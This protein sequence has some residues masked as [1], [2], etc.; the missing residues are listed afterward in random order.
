MNPSPASPAPPAARRSRQDPGENPGVRSRPG[1]GVRPPGVVVR[2]PAAALPAGLPPGRRTPA[3]A[4]S[5]KSV[6]A[7]SKSA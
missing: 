2:R 1:P 6:P 3:P 4:P 7:E 5:R